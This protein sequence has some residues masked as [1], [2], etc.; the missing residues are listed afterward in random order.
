MEKR[1]EQILTDFAQELKSTL[2]LPCLLPGVIKRKLLTNGEVAQLK[3]PN[4]PNLEKNYEFLNILKTKGSKAF[5]K[6]LE[7]LQEE[8]QHLGHEDLYAKLSSADSETMT[9]QMN[10]VPHTMPMCANSSQSAVEEI[11]NSNSVQS[12]LQILSSESVA[13]QSSVPSH[14]S[15]AESGG[16]IVTPISVASENR[17]IAYLDASL[18]KHLDQSMRGLENKIWSKIDTLE[19]VVKK[20]DRDVQCL[21]RL[22]GYSAPGSR[23]TSRSTLESSS[24]YSAASAHDH[25]GDYSS[26]SDANS[27]SLSHQ[28]KKIGQSWLINRMTAP[29]S[30]HRS[31]YKANK[32]NFHRPG[33]SSS[34]RSSE[35]QKMNNVRMYMSFCMGYMYMCMCM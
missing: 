14:Y 12:N 9:W 7:A 2:N 11:A 24:G 10:M 19:I 30:N 34:G 28:S 33:S 20:I 13:L 15:G 29:L 3:H 35:I 23:P 31:S 32:S 5:V 18:K 6:F 25:E 26:T 16:S 22:P 21:R 8:D 4:K 17:I 27:L 1:H